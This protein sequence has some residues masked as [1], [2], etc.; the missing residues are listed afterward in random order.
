LA[1]DISIGRNG[2]VW[3]IGAQP[4]GS[5]HRLDG[6]TWT[7]VQ[8]AGVRIAVDSIGNAAVVNSQG[9]IWHYNGQSWTQLSGAA[10]DIAI[11]AGGHVWVLGTNKVSGG[12]GLWRWDGANWV[13]APGGLKGIAVAADGKPLGVNVSGEFWRMQ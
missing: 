10:V 3:I 9:G 8:G 1:T 12:N 11:G 4:E 2:K 13:A 6:N 5:I 7:R